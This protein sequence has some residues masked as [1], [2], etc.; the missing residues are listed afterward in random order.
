MGCC[1]AG[2]ACGCAG[3]CAS[4]VSAGGRQPAGRPGR[5]GIE[6]VACVA[7]AVTSDLVA[8][9]YASGGDF[10]FLDAANEEATRVYER[11]GFT[12]FGA[13]LVYR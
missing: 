7:A 10:A 6:R 1:G 9:H 8:R 5:N 11:L 3:A 2:T 13:N 4:E 12:T